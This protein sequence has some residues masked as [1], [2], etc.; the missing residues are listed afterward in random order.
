MSNGIIIFLVESH[1][2]EFLTLFEFV[3]DPQNDVSFIR[4]M[5]IFM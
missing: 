1:V 2:S 5:Y 3:V 4:S